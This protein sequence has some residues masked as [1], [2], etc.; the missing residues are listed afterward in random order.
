MV[1]DEGQQLPPDPQRGLAKRGPRD[2][3]RESQENDN[4]RK[5]KNK[6]LSPRS[7]ARGQKD[8]STQ[9]KSRRIS[10]DEGIAEVEPESLSSNIFKGLDSTLRSN[11]REK[12]E[13]HVTGLKVETTE[14]EQAKGGVYQRPKI[15][16]RSMM[17]DHVND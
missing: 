12:G 14:S 9:S 17:N 5:K 13:I 6:L 4:E 8:N 10:G 1:M 11:H 7:E 2:D 15:P 3:K 16:K